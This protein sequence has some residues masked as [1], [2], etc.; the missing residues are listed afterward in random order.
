MIGFSVLLGIEEHLAL[1]AIGCLCDIIACR[2]GACLYYHNGSH[3]SML[4]RVY[5]RGNLR[6]V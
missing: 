5:N 4:K 2:Q 6:V 3:T 1:S